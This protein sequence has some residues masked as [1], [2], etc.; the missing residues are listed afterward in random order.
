MSTEGAAPGRSSSQ[1][2]AST[3]TC[4]TCTRACPRAFTDGIDLHGDGERLLDNIDHYKKIIRD[5]TGM[6]LCLP[7]C[8]LLVSGGASEVVRAK[9]AARGIAVATEGM[10]VMG[11]PVGTDAYIKGWRHTP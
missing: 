2:S 4:V 1:S 6:E 7:K 5:L 10:V 11:V 3:N 9:A 8:T